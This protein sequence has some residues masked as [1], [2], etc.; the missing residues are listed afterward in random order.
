[1]EENNSNETYSSEREQNYICFRNHCW[2]MCLGMIIAAF[3]GGF[4]A[5]YFV[6]D[7][8]TERSFRKQFRIPNHH[9]ERKM[10]NDLN[11]EFKKD[12]D[13]FDNI[14]SNA[15][16]MPNV[17]HFKANISPFFMPEKVKVKSEIENGN[18]NIIVNLKPFL[19]DENKINYNVTGRKLTVFGESAITNNSSEEDIAFS[20]DF[21]LPDN[22][23][24]MHIRKY[25]NDKNLVI[26]VPIRNK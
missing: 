9:F 10:I 12:M 18:Y 5:V 13:D 4:L 19:G 20:Y 8:I 15:E 3:L 7:Q 26:S 25:K 23:D 21:L 1:M 6:T 22:A 17:K 11:R 2:K 24:T 14:F 16:K